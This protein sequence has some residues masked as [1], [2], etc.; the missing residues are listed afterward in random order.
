MDI[1]NFLDKSFRTIFLSVMSFIKKQT[2]IEHLVDKVDA[3][4]IV[5][6]AAYLK[7]LDIAKIN[8]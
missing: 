5:T 4:Q 6:H 7:M 1:Y 8:I 3:N 2:N